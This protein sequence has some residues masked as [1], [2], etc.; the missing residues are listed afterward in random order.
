MNNKAFE[1]FIN[2]DY[3]ALSDWISNLNPYEFTFVATLIGGVIAP[4]LNTNQQNSLGNFFEQLG[5]TLETIAAQAQT[6]AAWQQNHN[7]NNNCQ[8]EINKLKEQL[9]KIMK[10]LNT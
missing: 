4:F 10:N 6:V 1:N 5:Q 9:E 2:Q 8:A 7:P 3:K